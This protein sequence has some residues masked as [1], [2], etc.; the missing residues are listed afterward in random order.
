[1]YVS[2]IGRNNLTIAGFMKA[3]E[4][5]KAANMMKAEE[6]QKKYGEKAHLLYL[7][8]SAMIYMECG[9]YE[10]AKLNFKEAEELSQ[11]LWTKSITAEAGSFIL[12][13]YTKPYDGEDFERALINL[14]ASFVYIMTE[15]YDEAMVE[16]R[17]LDLKLSEYNK[18]YENKNVYKEDALGRYLSGVLSEITDTKNYG[19]AFLYYKEAYEAYSNYLTKYG[20]PIPSFVIEDL[21]RTAKTSDRLDELNKIL[22]NYDKTKYI[23]QKKAEKLGKIIFINLNG[24]G[25]HKE[26]N[27]IFVDIPVNKGIMER[28]EIAFPKYVLQNPPCS[29]TKLVLNSA[30]K[31]EAKAELAENINAIASASLKDRENRTDFKAIARVILKQIAARKIGETIGKNISDNRGSGNSIAGMLGNI[32]GGAV[33]NATERADI[34][35]WN[36]LPAEIY[37][38]RLFVSPGEYDVSVERCGNIKNYI[39]KI[40]IKA[41]ETKFIFY[42]AIYN[43]TKQP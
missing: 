2:N 39:K 43:V 42:D 21:A 32:I 16:C 15:N 18:K 36:A 9:D 38:T 12:N 28:I 25:P 31:I 23:T 29:F 37:M 22:P 8:D 33:A 3:R 1:M 19:E 13:E 40:D 17:K 30:V 41:G 6:M 4:C 27:R 24:A 11:T 10:N 5:D 35:A 34:R 20:T 7:L 14:F 26:E